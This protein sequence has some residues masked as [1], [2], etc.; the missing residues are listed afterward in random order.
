MFVYHVGS[1]LLVIWVNDL[2]CFGN[3]AFFSHFKVALKHRWSTHHLRTKYTSPRWHCEV[4]FHLQML[5]S[6]FVLVCGMTK[7][8]QSWPLIFNW[9]AQTLPISTFFTKNDWWR[10]VLFDFQKIQYCGNKNDQSHVY[11][12]ICYSIT[13]LPTF[14]SS[15]FAHDTTALL[16]FKCDSDCLM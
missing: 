15:S 12:L 6:V 3:A 16:V 13:C 8:W 9:T 11:Y 5:K 7:K 4:F 10:S 14:I 1:S 2:L